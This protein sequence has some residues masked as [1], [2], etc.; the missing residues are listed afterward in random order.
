[1]FSILYS[2]PV[3]QMG[4]RIASTSADSQPASPKSLF[5]IT[6]QVCSCLPSLQLECTQLCIVC[7]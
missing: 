5:P 2:F 7:Q 1:M 4:N 6:S 3:L